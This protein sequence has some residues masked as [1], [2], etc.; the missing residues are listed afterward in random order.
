MKLD[1][2]LLSKFFLMMDQIPPSDLLSVALDA[3]RRWD[4]SE[5]D[6]QAQLLLEEQPYLMRFI[7]NLVDEMEEEDIEFLILALMS[8]QLGFKM[9]G[10]PLNIASVE[11]I[12]AKTTALVK[13]Y[14]EIEE[15][16]EVSLDDIF[17]SSD[18]PMVLQ[19]LFEIYYHDF[20]ETE[21]VGMAEIMNLL[22]VLEVIIG[23]VEDSTIDTPST[24]QDSVSEI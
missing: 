6:K 4:D 9:R 24:N 16:E 2:L 15:E 1:G 7:M 5:Y 22:L 12:E 19:Q 18:N 3:I 17:K 11:S 14:D 13:K 21:T 8:V 23:G 10:I 20:L